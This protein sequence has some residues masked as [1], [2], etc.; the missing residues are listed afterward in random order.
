MKKTKQND[1]IYVIER[2]DKK[3]NWYSL[4]ENENIE[5]IRDY[6]EAIYYSDE[7]DKQYRILYEDRVYRFIH[8]ALGLEH[9]IKRIEEKYG[10]IPNEHAEEVTNSIVGRKELNDNKYY[11][12]I[13]F[14]EQEKK[15]ELE[16]TE[17]LLILRTVYSLKLT[18]Y[19]I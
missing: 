6:L 15:K 7:K 5:K 18:N 11:D 13:D 8:G 3:N 14:K 19:R 12:D 17:E 9:C 10:L 1:K 4:Y 16:E 2:L